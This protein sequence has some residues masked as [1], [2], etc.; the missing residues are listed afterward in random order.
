MTPPLGHTPSHWR[1][2]GC[3]RQDR[4]A[5]LTRAAAPRA[6]RV[7][8]RLWGWR[9]PEPKGQGV[10]PPLQGHQARAR[11]PDAAAS[12]GSGGRTRAPGPRVRLCVPLGSARLFCTARTQW[13]IRTVNASSA[14][15][16]FC[17]GT[18]VQLGFKMDALSAMYTSG[19]SGP[20]GSFH[21]TPHPSL[22]ASRHDVN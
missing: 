2:P 17:Q 5:H 13:V 9:P 11:P 16:G 8:A 10:Q 15:G 1:A 7:S 22:W 18:Q 6:V 3:L 20:S 14:S 19:L 21:V 12:S 4:D